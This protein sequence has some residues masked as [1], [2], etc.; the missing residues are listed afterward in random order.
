MKLN[1]GKATLSC[2]EKD[3]GDAMIYPI[4]GTVSV[5]SDEDVRPQLV[6][7]A[8]ADTFSPT[9]GTR[10]S[11][12]IHRRLPAKRHPA[13]ILRIYAV[14]TDGRSFK[15]EWKWGYANSYEEERVVTVPS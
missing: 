3:M 9:I 6:K 11:L 13:K 1:F 10:F 7:S 2:S 15:I 14:S 4:Y 12:E 8:M 5:T